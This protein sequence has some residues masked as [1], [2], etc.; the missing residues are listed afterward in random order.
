MTD[1][2]N[3]R[4]MRANRSLIS[5]LPNRILNGVFIGLIAL[6]RIRDLILALGEDGYPGSLTY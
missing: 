1:G 2:I 6:A 4:A 5:A 3:A